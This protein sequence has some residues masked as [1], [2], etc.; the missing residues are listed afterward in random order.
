MVLLLVLVL[1]ALLTGV[2]V[3]F[4]A[5]TRRFLR[6]A[7]NFRDEVKA[8]AL[9]RA[10]VSAARALLKEDARQDQLTKN[11][12]D[13]PTDFW[14]TPVSDYPLGDG[15][16]SIAIADE[17][18]KVNLNDLAVSGT[19]TRKEKIAQLKRLFE[20]ATVDPTLVDAVVDW[21][22]PDHDLEPRGAESGYYQ[23]RKPPYRARNGAVNTLSELHLVKGITTPAY[24]LIA[25]HMTVYPQTPDGTVNLNAASVPVIQSLDARINDAMARDLTLARPFKSLDDVDRVSGM[26]QIAKELRASQAYSV[27]SD[28]FSVRVTATVNQTVRTARAVLYRPEKSLRV[29]LVSLRI[30]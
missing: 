23:T 12:Y 14:A 7:G 19:Q 29:D 24:D 26:Q 16:V 28:Y 11:P 10:G 5:S 6:E 4:D 25:P 30:E 18:G 20:S 2:I 22:D 27:R 1:L 15:T 8:I 13:G 21:V 9:A 17:R 3:D